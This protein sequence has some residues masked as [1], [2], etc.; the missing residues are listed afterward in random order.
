[1]ANL[2]LLMPTWSDAGTYSGGSWVSSL[3]LTNLKTQQPQ[4]V[5]RST[6]AAT[7]STK[8]K[9]DFGRVLPISMFALINTNCTSA[10]TVRLR[11]SL[12]Q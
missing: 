6:S 7:S 9:L 10:A 11:V 4:Q 2:H 1:M 3:P 5:A 8:F 12:L